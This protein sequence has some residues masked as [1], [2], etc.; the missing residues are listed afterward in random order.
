MEKLVPILGGTPP[1]GKLESAKLRPRAGSSG[2]L[3]PAP[4]GADFVVRTA[5]ETKNF[6]GL[7][8]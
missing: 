4:A 5:R 8:N 2:L 3:T 6:L 7:I 1:D